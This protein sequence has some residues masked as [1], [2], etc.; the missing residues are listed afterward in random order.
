M[1]VIISNPWHERV[2]RSKNEFKEDEKCHN[3]KTL[4][5]GD[6][7][8]VQNSERGV[9][10]HQRM[11]RNG[12][13]KFPERRKGIV[14]T[15]SVVVPQLPSGLKGLRWDASKYVETEPKR[16]W[17]LQNPTAMYI[18]KKLF[19]CKVEFCNTR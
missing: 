4:W 2:A 18:D 9:R 10:Q 5:H 12:V 1:N 13:C 3:L 8:T 6:D 14:S 11:D 7:H 15:S 19:E 16:K 17:F